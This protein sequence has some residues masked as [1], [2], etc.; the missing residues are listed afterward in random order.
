M[1]YSIGQW[2]YTHSFFLKFL[3]FCVNSLLSPSHSRWFQFVPSSSSLFQ[4]VP[5]S[6][7]SFQLVHCF[8][9]YV[10]IFL[11]WTFRYFSAFF[12]RYFGGIFCT[13]HLK[14]M[15]LET[16]QLLLIFTKSWLYIFHTCIKFRLFLERLY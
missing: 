8:S 15:L 13:F 16:H 2:Y 5:G 10:L 6:S 1:L 9:V 3:V 7:N 11:S 4:L 14:Q 12:H